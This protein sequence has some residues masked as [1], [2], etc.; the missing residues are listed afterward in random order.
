MFPQ[1]ARFRCCRGLWLCVDLR[2]AQNVSRAAEQITPAAPACTNADCLDCHADPTLTLARHG[3]GCRWRGR[4]PTCSCAPFMAPWIAPIATS[5]CSPSM[6]SAR[7]RRLRRLSCGR[8]ARLRPKQ[9]RRELPAR[10]LRGDRLRRLPRH[11]RGHL[12]EAP[13]FPG[14]RAQPAPSLRQVPQ[15]PEND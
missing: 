14:L 4:T 12:R 5:A 7:L 8:G 2:G 1:F 6:T 9:P 15:Q 11:A 10:C 13:G 3:R